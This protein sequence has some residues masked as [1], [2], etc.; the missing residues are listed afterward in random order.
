[1]ESWR[2]SNGRKTCL[3]TIPPAPS[4]PSSHGAEIV[5]PPAVTSTGRAL[6]RSTSRRERGMC[7]A[8]PRRPARAAPRRRPRG[9]DPQVIARSGSGTRALGVPP[10]RTSTARRSAASDRRS[11]SVPDRAEPRERQGPA[12]DAAAAG[13]FARM[14]AVH[15]RH[16]RAGPGQVARR[17]GARRSGPDDDRVEASP[18]GSH[19]SI[20]PTPDLN[21]ASLATKPGDAAS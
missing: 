10:P 3:R 19:P 13:L 21:A 8:R 20:R 7:V 11:R 12:G 5:S 2:R 1:M 17:H 6:A 4:A 16:P 15:Q 9:E 14:A 18:H